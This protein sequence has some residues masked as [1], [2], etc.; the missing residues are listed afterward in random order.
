MVKLKMKWKIGV[1]LVLLILFL[2]AIAGI[3]ATEIAKV[4]SREELETYEQDGWKISVGMSY[5]SPGLFSFTVGENVLMEGHAFV[6]L[7]KDKI[8]CGG[9]SG[10]QMNVFI[11]RNGVLVYSNTIL[12]DDNGDYKITD[13]IPREPGYYELVFTD[14]YKWEWHPYNVTT[15]FYASE[16]DSDGDGVPDQYDYAPY[17]PNMQSRNDI[18]TPGFEAVFAIAGL[19][20]VAYLLRRRG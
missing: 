12:T 8:L 17:D 9:I 13:F 11:Y 15:S 5:I 4:Y 18:R 2:S 14:F 19:L 10:F 3:N 20:A 16:K 7:K 6:N 1:V